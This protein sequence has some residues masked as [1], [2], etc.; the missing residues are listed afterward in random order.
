[1]KKYILHLTVCL[2]FLMPGSSIIT[3]QSLQKNT[4]FSST[5][6]R[7]YKSGFLEKKGSLLTVLHLKGTSYERGYQ[8][9]MLQEDLDR[10][11][12]LNIT[13]LA[14]WFGGED[15]EKGI[16]ALQDA[17]KAMEPFIPYQYRQ[18]IKGMA[19]ALA[20]KGSKVTYDDIIL[21]LTG[22][23]FA[24]MDTGHDIM[25]PRNRDPF[26]PI[27]RCS[28]FSAWGRAVKDGKLIAAGNSDY[29]DTEL[30]LRNRPV[31]VIDPTDG[32]YGY[33]AALWDVFFTASG[34][35]EKGI[36]VN[37]KLVG[38]DDESLRGVS[39]EL[40]LGLVLQK[41]DSI[42]DALEI[43][44]VYPRTC[45][46]IVHVA[47]AKT[48]LAA[49]IEYT[50]E[51]IAVRYAEPGKEILWSTNHFNC[52]PEW[53]GYSGF[54]M[55]PAYDKRAKLADISTV[56][57]WQ[58][59]LEKEGMGRAGRYSRFHRLLLKNYGKIDIEIA[60]EIISDRYS[61]KQDKILKPTETTGWQDYPIM[62]CRPDWIMAKHIQFYKHESREHRELRV[63]SGNVSSY[64]A[65]PA[66]GDIWWAVGIPP[67][68]YT[69]GYTHM[70][71]HK[72]LSR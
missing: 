59:S 39:S 21:H 37:G 27:S 62:V 7:K 36:A 29:Y 65:L 28:S 1:M 60:R 52:V 4:P 24:M 71:L 14:A 69:S 32:G 53:Q 66:S 20:A 5:V 61:L 8:R 30:E 33:T 3:C 56:E 45:G 51:H 31:A 46:I 63:K 44:T 40:L 50:A 17:K 41:T 22:A 49:V 11:T 26:P 55:A 68:A 35:N 58:A 70:N 13:E 12:L 16:A 57:K 15:L 19:D 18:E 47:D 23:E 64:I 43:L 38:A 42:A 2:L 67:A 34:I 9:G 72:E 48:N 25:K 10:V 54:N 6:I